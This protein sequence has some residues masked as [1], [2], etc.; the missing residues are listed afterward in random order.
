MLALLATA[1]LGVEACAPLQALAQSVLGRPG[2]V[3][4]GPVAYPGAADAP[5]CII[6][7]EGTQQMGSNFVAVAA[8]LDQAVQGAGWTRDIA[9]DADGPDGTAAGYNRSGEELAVSVNQTGRGEA[10]V[11]RVVIGLRSATGAATPAAAPGAAPLDPACLSSTAW[12]VDPASAPIQVF[13]CRPL[14]DIPSPDA[15][16]FISY[17]RP[18]VDGADGGFTRVKPMASA[19]EGQVAFVVQDNTGGSYTGQVTVTGVLNPDGYMAAA[20]L[21]VK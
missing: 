18:Q 7:V 16:G 17:D 21:V 8:K 3:A 2:E 11:Y 19:P 5:G 4:V 15:D 10:V 1:I 13:G 9:A 14:V 12:A 6:Q 20:G